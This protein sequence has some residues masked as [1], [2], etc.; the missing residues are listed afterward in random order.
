MLSDPLVLGRRVLFAAATTMEADCLLAAA[1]A[2]GPAAR[3]P[4]W[5]LIPVDS[6]WDLVITGVGK[7]C[8]AGA[9]ARTLDPA[10]HAGAVSF[11]ICGTLAESAAGLGEVIAATACIFADEGLLTP[12]GFTD[13]AAMGFGPG[14]FEGMAVPTE[15]PWVEALARAGAEPGVIA[16]VSTCSG[17]DALAREVA[18]R[19]GARA[20]AMEGAAVALAA[21]RLGL[22]CGEVRA[23][24][25]TTGNRAAQRWD[26][27]AA[28]QA[29]T[30][31][32][33]RL[34]GA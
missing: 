9:V 34:R 24:S 27:P 5:E 14:D 4:E 22:A 28:R 16:T 6:A 20:E 21:H 11:G 31:V 19:T 33:A 12:E 10:R 29:L 25:N 1:R 26:L 8:A 23:V 17:T 30:A 7:S 32:L 18:R 15:S 3:L 2:D 13:C